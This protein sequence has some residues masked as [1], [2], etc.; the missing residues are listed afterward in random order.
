[1][2]VTHS[3]PEVENETFQPNILR[4]KELQ[5]IFHFYRSEIIP[6]KIKL[7]QFLYLFASES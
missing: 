6:L 4:K 3:V 7:K 1:M 2:N 5:F